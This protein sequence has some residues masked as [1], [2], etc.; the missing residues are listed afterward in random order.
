MSAM[1]ILG[2]I[3][4]RYS[5]E[6]E[7]AAALA[8]LRLG[9]WRKA[10]DL[11]KPLFKKDRSKF[12]DLLVA[13]NRGLICEL[14]EKNLISEARTVA[15]YLKT[16]APPET[17]SRI[18]ADILAGSRPRMTAHEPTSAMSRLWPIARQIIASGESIHDVGLLDDLVACFQKPPEETE[19]AMA[20]FAAELCA[21]Q[22]ACELAAGGDWEAASQATRPLSANSPFRHWK[23]FL[24]GWGLCFRG[25]R[26]AAAAAFSRLPP[27]TATE[28][29][30]RVIL[31]QPG[32]ASLRAGSRA[33]WW[34]A[35]SGQ[36]SEWSA[37]IASA[38][39]SLRSCRWQAA[40]DA[41]SSSL[42]AEL[43]S[44]GCGLGAALADCL[45]VPSDPG[46]DDATFRQ[47][48][49]AFERALQ[50]GK[51]QLPTTR[52]IGRGFILLNSDSIQSSCLEA[53]FLE[54]LAA[55]STLFGSDR[56]RDSV[57]FEWLGR[58][59]LQ[60]NPGGPFG[61]GRPV[62]RDPARARKAFQRAVDA[63]PENQDAWS[64][65][66]E[67]LQ[68]LGRKSDFNKLLDQL[69]AK[70][71]DN[72][73]F[74]VQA[75]RAAEARGAATKAIA[76]AEAARKLDPLDR[77]VRSLTIEATFRRAAVLAKQG[78]SCAGLWRQMQNDLEPSSG[79]SDPT[80]A[81][82]SAHIRQEILEAGSSPS[83]SPPPSRAAA[84][85]AEHF[86]RALY[87]R[88]LTDFQD[89][90]WKTSVRE[91]WAAIT[92]AFAFYVAIQS[93]PHFSKF[94]ENWSRG[95]YRRWPDEE[96]FLVLMK[97]DPLGALR[98][99]ETVASAA[100]VGGWCSHSARMILEKLKS[101]AGQ[102]C[103]RRRFP[104]ADPAIR[105]LWLGVGV[106]MGIWTP[107]RN[108][109][110]EILALA[111]CGIPEVETAAR[112]ISASFP[113]PHP[114]DKEQDDRDE[115]DDE[116]PDFHGFPF[117][118][119]IGPGDFRDVDIARAMKEMMKEMQASMR[120]SRKKKS[121]KKS[122][123]KSKK[124]SPQPA[125]P[126]PPSPIMPKT[127]DQQPEFPF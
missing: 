86:F 102:L 114:A 10:R 47:R 9:K 32:A 31:R 118:D 20:A 122:P 22:A 58:Q 69:A 73:G 6:P 23:A 45:F 54:L 84:L 25:D 38:D 91:S 19:P 66:L 7:A 68:V 50:A 116:E 100:T 119:D 115:E 120:K 64:G 36:P 90:D 88:P 37:A 83:P 3:E 34:L 105:C 1:Q 51:R 108:D 55:E 95:F 104:E 4:T 82:W 78:R 41:L 14:L 74:L 57:G 27:G 5:G 123:A 56:V 103:A 92:P 94:A 109:H 79:C 111:S 87:K 97:S 67:S 75:A 77:E 53:D 106:S 16:I 30:S 93:S 107:G 121:A 35:C 11:I 89:A 113:T 124:K 15:D 96:D 110:Q 44:C 60:I 43:T 21:V 2:E 63:D 76:F 101:A 61:M 85:V 33:G 24:K 8:A 125:P 112:K 13:A 39:A 126:K 52:A 62:V 99:Y 42:G 49:Q 72:K 40:L 26:K 80:L 81:R 98:F 12:L 117:P 71:P 28:I 48:E 29:A 46:L 65:L 70:F 17:V 59:F 127:S 18:E